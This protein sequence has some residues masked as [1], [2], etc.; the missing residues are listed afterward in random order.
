MAMG[1]LLIAQQRDTH[2]A[3]EVPSLINDHL[4]AAT[5]IPLMVC[6]YLRLADVPRLIAPPPATAAPPVAKLHST[7]R[8]SP[9]LAQNSMGRPATRV[10]STVTAQLPASCARCSRCPMS[11]LVDM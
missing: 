5:T 1:N 8:Q 4:L 9:A 2:L 7:A 10:T 6:S 3:A 11:S